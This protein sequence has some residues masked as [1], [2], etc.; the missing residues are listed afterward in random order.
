[1][2]L[3][4][5]S[6]NTLHGVFFLLVSTFLLVGCATDHETKTPRGEVI[7]E[8]FLEFPWGRVEAYAVRPPGGGFSPEKRYPAI[9]LLHGAD[10]RAQRFRRA[11]LAH[12]HDGFIMMSIS[13]PGFGAS[14]G[15]EDF[16]GPKS[17][18]AALGAVRYL[19]TRQS[20]RKD[21]IFVYGVGQGASVAALAAARGANISGLVLEDGF[22][23][24]EKTYALL[25]QK[26]KNRMRALLGGKP[27]Q[28][29]EAYRERSPIRV[30]EQDKS[31][32]TASAQPRR[33]L[34]AQRRRDFSKSHRGK[35]RNSGT[36]ENKKPGPVRIT[37]TPQH[38]ETGHS[39][40]QENTQNALIEIPSRLSPRIRSWPSDRKPRDE[41]ERAQPPSRADRGP[42][43]FVCT[44]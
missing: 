10:A 20:V 31:P 22:Y 34:S 1:M 6:K 3:K 43:G 35:R 42:S 7:R 33:F 44:T 28:R 24:L 2:I 11:M 25:S 12:V 38:L 15:P 32:G 30:A 14:T 4:K 9:L 26:R 13:L 37:H 21:G 5:I 27:A 8:W 36:A 40:H 23:D 18:G 19:G 16:A 39:L 41:N 29:G 17:V